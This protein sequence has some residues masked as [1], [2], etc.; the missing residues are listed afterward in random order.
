MRYFLIFGQWSTIAIVL[1]FLGGLIPQPLLAQTSDSYQA[2]LIEAAR[3]LQE[4][5]ETACCQADGTSDLQILGQG[6]QDAY[7]RA[8]DGP[9][10]EAGLPNVF[11]LWPLLDPDIFN[12]LEQGDEVPKLD[13]EVDAAL[14]RLQV[15]IDQLDAMS[16]DQ[17]EA[18]LAA[19]ESVLARSEFQT[20]LTLWQR[21]T[22]WLSQLLERFAPETQGEGASVGWL[23]SLISW[24]L[25]IVAAVALVGLLG[26]WIQ[27][28]V[29]SFVGNAEKDSELGLDGHPLTAR[30]AREQ[31]AQQAESGNY[32]GAVRRLYLAALLTMEEKGAIRYDRSQT[33]REVLAQVQDDATVSDHLRPIVETFDDVWYGIH[34]PDHQTYADYTHEVERL[35]EAANQG[36]STPDG[37]GR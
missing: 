33:N 9:V 13:E 22:R 23:G 1:I 17:T 37:Q 7:L 6:Y 28:M 29:G 32:R 14:A 24:T 34:E 12:A 4:A 8:A 16:D 27:R 10:T 35:T 18:R 26:Y 2:R 21:F 19:L 3:I 20:Q 30:Q 31:A 15:T 11:N 5:K 36:P 25:A